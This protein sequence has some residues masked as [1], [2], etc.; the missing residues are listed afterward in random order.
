VNLAARLARE[1]RPNEALV[2]AATRAAARDELARRLA[3]PCE[4]RLAGFGTPVS[5]WR[6]S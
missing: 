2:S 4:L 6:L 5:A 3:V 1:A